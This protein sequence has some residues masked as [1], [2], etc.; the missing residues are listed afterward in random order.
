MVKMTLSQPYQCSDC[1]HPT[2]TYY[3]NEELPAWV[4][5]ECSPYNPANRSK[6]RQEAS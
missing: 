1:K 2:E 6:L 3:W 4:C 5:W